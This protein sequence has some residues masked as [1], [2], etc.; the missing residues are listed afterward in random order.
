[1]IKIQLEKREGANGY[2][3]RQKIIQRVNLSNT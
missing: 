2:L 3:F 1:M